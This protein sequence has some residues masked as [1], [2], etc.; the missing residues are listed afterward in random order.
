MKQPKQEAAGNT[1]HWIKI[2]RRP[3]ELWVR[4]EK[5]QIET[6]RGLKAR[7]D[8]IREAIDEFLKRRGH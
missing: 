7:G 8:L 4:L 6:G 5:Y 3:P 2:D 1:P